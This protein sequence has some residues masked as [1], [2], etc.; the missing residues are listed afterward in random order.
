MKKRWIWKTVLIVLLSL[1]RPMSVQAEVDVDPSYLDFGDVDEIIQEAEGEQTL[2]EQTGSRTIG[3]LLASLI[4]GET[5]IS[6]SDWVKAF[7]VSLWGNMQEYMGLMLQVIALTLLAQIF[8]TLELHFG[9]GAVGEIGFLAVYGCLIWLLVQS[10]QI[11]YQE[12]SGLLEHVRDLS[13]YMLPA[14]AAVAVASGYG[15]SSV[16]QSELMTSGFSVILSV[17]KNGFAV[18]IVWVTI[19]ELVNF[20]S[21]RAI[22]SQLTSLVRTILEKGIKAITGLYLFLMGVFGIV[23]PS[24]DKTVYKA[25]SAVMASVPVVGSAMSGAMDSVLAGSMLIKNGIGATGCIALLC[26]CLIP[27]ARLTAIWLMY[28][29][30]AA[31]LSPIADPRIIQVLSALGR[32]TAMLLGLLVSG[33]VIFTGAVGIFVMTTGQ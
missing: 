22:L 27:A 32:S 16:L 20:M 18:C 15:I 19:L 10:F 8:S 30:M 28:R 13:L 6:W 26:I 4:Q 3:E 12:A 7:G 29:M 1:W 24:V 25:S 33:I 31:F 11:A 2:Q 9:D 17:M 5:S 14:M 23:M 21:K